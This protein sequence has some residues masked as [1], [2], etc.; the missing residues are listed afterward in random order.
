MKRPTKFVKPLTDEQRDQVKE[1]MKSEAPQRRRMRAHA[2]LLSSRRYSIDQIAD[3]YQVDRDR[4]SEW[5]NWWDDYHFDDLDDDPRGGR[6]PKLTEKEQNKAIDLVLKEPRSLRQALSQIATQIGSRLS[7]STLKRLLAEDDYVWKRLRR[8][9]R[10]FRSEDEFRAAQAEMA[11]LRIQALARER[12]FDLWYFDEAGFTLQ[13]CVPYAWQKIGHTLELASGSG[14]RQNVLGFFNLHHGFQSFAFQGSIDTHTVIHCFD[15][16]R[17]RLKRPALVII[18][19]APIHTSE[20]FEEQLE[21]WEQ[22]DVHVKCSG[23]TLR[24]H[25]RDSVCVKR[26][27]TRLLQTRLYPIW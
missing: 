26:Y 11:Q 15:L 16:F 17:A 7:R 19:N 9:L 12:K 3:I 2:V 27:T 24:N 23:P 13:P 21:R 14:P 6:P 18:D 1:I 20:E 4:V 25:R 22:C 8:S 5:L 10:S